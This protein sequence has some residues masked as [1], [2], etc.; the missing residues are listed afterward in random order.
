VTSEGRAIPA[1]T[2]YHAEEARHENGD[3]GSKAIYLKWKI[4]Y[5]KAKDIFKLF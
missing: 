5:K 3:V 2:G 1:G 4:T